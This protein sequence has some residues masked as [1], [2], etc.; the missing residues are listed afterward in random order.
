MPLRKGVHPTLNR[1]RVVLT[2]G[3]TVMTEMAWQHPDWRK[4][5]TKVRDVDYLNS[6]TFTGKEARVKVTGQR[7]KFE[8]RYKPK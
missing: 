8:Q 6:P 2:N 1:V 3:A 5:I 4:V 7:A